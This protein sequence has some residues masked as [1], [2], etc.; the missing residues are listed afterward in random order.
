MEID[1]LT[2]RGRGYKGKEK[3]KNDGQKTSCFVCG[4]VGHMAKGCWSRKRARAVRCPTTRARKGKA[5]AK[6]KPV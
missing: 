5:K 4:R 6:E 1:A 2:K 3:N